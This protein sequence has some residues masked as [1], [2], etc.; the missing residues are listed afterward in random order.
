L[1]E[2]AAVDRGSFW[3]QGYEQLTGRV[4]SGQPCL[5]NQIRQREH[6]YLN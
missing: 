4:G 1:L 2:L 3:L 6:Y 5:E